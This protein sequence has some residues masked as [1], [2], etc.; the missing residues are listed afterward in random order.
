MTKE[1]YRLSIRLEH[2]DKE[3]EE[4]ERYVNSLKYDIQYDLI[5]SRLR[6]VGE[7][8]KLSLKVEE[9]LAQKTTLGKGK[10]TTQSQIFVVS[11]E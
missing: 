4:I 1:F 8:K 6:T 9:K 10:I 2:N 3:T 11:H 7:A 5:F